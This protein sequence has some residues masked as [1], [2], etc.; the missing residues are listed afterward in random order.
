MSTATE[1]LYYRDAGLLEF[2][3]TALEGSDPCRVVLDRTAFY[4]TSGGQPHDTGTLNDIAVI[5]VIDDGDRVIHVLDAP[6]AR[7]PVRGVINRDRRIDHMQQHTAQ[8]LLSALAE[9]LFGWATVSVHFGAHHSTIEFDT[10]EALPAQ[11][12]QLEDRANVVVGE[13]RAIVVSIEAAESAIA[14]RRASERDGALRVITIEGIDR[15]ACG[16]THVLRTSEIGA[17][18]HAGVERIRGRV[19]VA[20][21]AGRR[22]LHRLHH[23]DGLIQ[24]VAVA[25]SCAIDDAATVAVNRIDELA[26]VTREHDLTEDALAAARLGLLSAATPPGPDGVRRIVHRIDQRDLEQARRIARVAGSGS[27]VVFIAMASAPPTIVVGASPDSGID[28]GAAL[29]SALDAVGGRGG[30]SPRY[31]QGAAPDAA[32]LRGLVDRLSNTM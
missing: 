18:Y 17:V 22:T 15:S 24:D 26:R 25:L 7:G 10:A 11:L 30:G 19:R 29:K 6:L 12:T 14:L 2:T 27:G 13:A 9:D 16:G 28:A 31:A 23:R 3:A 8:H 21:V 20:F 4:P 1:R 32:L 5:D